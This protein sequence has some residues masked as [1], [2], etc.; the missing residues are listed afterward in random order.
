MK[1]KTFESKSTTD[2]DK[3]CNDFEANNQ[4]RATQTAAYVIEG[5]VVHKAVLFY[6]ED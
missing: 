3:L 2:L 6:K 4:V 5:I 1:I